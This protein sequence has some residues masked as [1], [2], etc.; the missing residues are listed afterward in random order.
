MAISF[1]AV[2]KSSFKFL[3]Y[4][5][6]LKLLHMLLLFICEALEDFLVAFCKPSILNDPRGKIQEDLNQVSLEVT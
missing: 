1:W 2:Q 3:T 5:L 6:S 4:F